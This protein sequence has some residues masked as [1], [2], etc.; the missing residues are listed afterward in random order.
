MSLRNYIIFS[1]TILKLVENIA[2]EFNMKIIM[3]LKII[4]IILFGIFEKQHKIT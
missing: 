2:R 4:L 1:G 3:S